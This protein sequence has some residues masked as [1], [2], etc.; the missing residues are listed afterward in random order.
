MQKSLALPDALP[1]GALFWIIERRT[2][3][4]ITNKQYEVLKAAIYMLPSGDAFKALPKEE[5]ETIMAAQVVLIDLACKKTADN[6][7]TAA[8]IAN[9][10]KTDK[11]YARSRKEK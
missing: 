8:Y 5:Q 10:R 4:N 11:N 1:A 9:R 2:A 6:K 3:L 7:R